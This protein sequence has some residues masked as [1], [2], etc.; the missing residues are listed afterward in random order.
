MP[1]P[2]AP[3]IAPPRP[4]SSAPPRPTSSAPP[5]PASASSAPPPSSADTAEELFEA[6]H[7]LAQL[8]SAPDGARFCLR[9]AMSAVPSL[10]ALVHLRDPKTLDLVVVH[11]EGPRADGL[12][13]TRTP[14][15]DSLVARSARAGKPTVATYGAEPDAEKTKCPRH[16]FFDPWSVVVVPVIRGGQL[17]GMLEMIDP[18]SGNP[19]DEKAQAALSYVADR[20]GRFLA[21]HPAEPMA[22]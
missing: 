4:A 18:I 8:A 16:A 17:L 10:A 9:V 13:R 6:M 15:A 19:S 1:A 3:V 22:T 14:Q 11:A 7:D 5:R 20:L 12:L 2:K 21:E